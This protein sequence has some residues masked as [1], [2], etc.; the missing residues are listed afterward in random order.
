MPKL[1]VMVSLYNSGEWIDNRL[2]NLLSSSANKDMEVWCLNADSPDERDRSIPQ[3]YPVKYIELDHRNT[4]YEAWNH[5][6]KNTDSEFITNANTDDI[7]HPYAYEK[8]IKALEEAGPKFGFSYPS[9]FST[10]VPNQKWERLSSHDYAGIP[11]QYNGDLTTSGVGH[12]PLWRRSLHDTVGLFNTEYR[13]LADADMWAKCYYVAKTKF[14]WVNEY[15]GCY[16]WRN[17][18]NLWN[19]EIS[20]TEWERYHECLKNYRAGKLV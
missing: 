2:Q 16:L 1:V 15:L 12:F 14:L 18:E 19:R 20:R 9:W 6:I 10:S 17:G 7:V 3:Q 4:V 13:A 5:I 8:L 11:G